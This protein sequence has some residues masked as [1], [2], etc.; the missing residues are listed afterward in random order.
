MLE[1]PQKF[2]ISELFRKL[3]VFFWKKSIEIA[4]IGNFRLEE[5]SKGNIA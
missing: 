2:Q 5:V 1:N 3:Q 4:T